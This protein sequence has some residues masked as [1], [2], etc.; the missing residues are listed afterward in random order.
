M[1]VHPEGAMGQGMLVIFIL[2]PLSVVMVLGWA[3]G[4]WLRHADRRRQS[5]GRQ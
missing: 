3:V 5:A 2:M 4:L 1:K